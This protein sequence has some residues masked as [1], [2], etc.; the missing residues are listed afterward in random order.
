MPVAAIAER[1]RARGARLL[2]DGAHGPGLVDLDLPTFGADWYVGNLHKWLCAPKGAGFLW[3]RAERQADLHPVVISHRLGEGFT[4]EFDLVGTRDVSAWLAAPAAIAFHRALGGAVLRAR[5][6]RLAIAG[7][8]RLAGRLATE[9]G[10]PDPLFAGMATVRLPGAPTRE[11][12]EALKAI[13]WREHRI[14]T[15]IQPF[16]G[17]LWL[18]LSIQAYNDLDQVERLGEALVPL[19]GGA[20]AGRQASR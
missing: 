16:A 17:A 10:A 15:Q 7:A 12:A 19:V 18:R 8:H 9:T 6:R 2:V 1:C 20:V 11:R 14:E 13:L 3:A 4:A 5:N